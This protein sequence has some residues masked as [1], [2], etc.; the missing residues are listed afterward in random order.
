MNKV[1]LVIPNLL[2]PNEIASDICSGLRL[3]ALEKLLARGSSSASGTVSGDEDFLENDLC[4]LFGTAG[5]TF[6][7][8]PV[9]PISAAFDG[10][11]DGCWLRADPVHL[12]LD[13]SRMLLSVVPLTTEDASALCTSL[14][15]HFAGQGMEFFAPHPQRWYVR[16]DVLPHLRTKPLSQTIGGDVRGHLPVGEDATRWHGVLNEIQMLLYSHPVNDAREVR[17]EFPINSVWFWGGGCSG[18][19]AAK[20]DYE[21]VSSENVLPEMFAAAAGVPFSSWSPNWQEK[22]GRQLLV[23]TGLSTALQRNN[24]AAWRTALQDFETGYAQPLLQALRAGKIE[25]LEIDIAGGQNSRY[26]GLSR[27]N[28]LA[29]WRRSK[30]LFRYSAV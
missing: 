16:T 10:L 26:L 21:H 3:P 27:F 8:A 19:V 20:A 7:G 17:G 18:N 1:H 4:A 9:A 30:P 29:F 25:R 28:A 13:Q 14:N 22:Q 15:A 24:L 5:D 6:S 2:L 11:P 12:H 23:W